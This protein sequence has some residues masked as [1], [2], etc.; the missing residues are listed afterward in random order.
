MNKINIT[1]GR[2]QPFTQGHLNMLTDGKN[3]CIIYKISSPSQ[4]GQIKIKGRLAK[5]S[6]IEN[7]IR[8]VDNGAVGDLTEDEKEILKR[9]FTN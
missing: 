6:Q 5:R 4:D 7:V 9:P 2:F 1:I 3:P 8:Y